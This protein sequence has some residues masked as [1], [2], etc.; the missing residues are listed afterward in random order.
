M[1]ASW[2]TRSR[3]CK[4]EIW[5]NE[6]FI[7]VDT[8]PPTYSKAKKKGVTAGKFKG[9]SEKCNILINDGKMLL[10]ERGLHLVQKVVTI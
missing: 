4:E 5:W 9:L 1:P 3:G 2:K 8:P 10:Y 6:I 7:S